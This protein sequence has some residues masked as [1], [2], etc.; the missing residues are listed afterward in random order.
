MGFFFHLT[1]TLSS[2]PEAAFLQPKWGDLQFAATGTIVCTNNLQVSPLRM[3]MKPSCCGRDDNVGARQKISSTLLMKNERKQER[4]ADARRFLF[5]TSYSLPFASN[6]KA[7]RFGASP[8]KITQLSAHAWQL[9]RLGLVNCYLV[10]ESDSFTLID[11]G[12]SG[13]AESI[14]D[15]ARKCGAGA[16]I[17]RILLT[18][19]HGDHIAS[20]DALHHL[21]GKV[22]VAISH[23]DALLLPKP[24]AQNRSLDANEPQCKVKGWFPGATTTPTHLVAHA[25]LFGSLRCI[26]TPGHTPGHFSFLDERDGTLYAGDAL[27]TVG[28]KPHVSGWAPWFFPLPNVATWH[29]PTART[30][31][32]QLIQIVPAETPIRRIAPGH[33]K[34]LEGSNDLLEAA[35]IET[36]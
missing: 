12:I 8:V 22:D 29:R 2:R 27:C 17:S 4:P 9:T 25:E 34:V 16:P 31:I 18:H 23:R 1:P 26:T 28:G 5:P 14:L 6:S 11:T 3:T 13:S 10:R 19:A 30:S 21:L 15:A 32:E 24:P 36:S 35:L 20:L 33:G 7:I